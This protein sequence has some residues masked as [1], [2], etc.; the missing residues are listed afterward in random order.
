M[1]PQSRR[2]WMLIGA[3]V[4]GASALGVIAS[5]T[6]DD[7]LV[8]F[9]TPTEL[10]ENSNKARDVT[11]RLGGQVKADSKVWDQEAR[12]LEF[13]VT[14]GTT[15]V[16]VVFNGD[17]PDMFRE[18]IGVVVEGSLGGDGLFHSETLLVKHSNEYQAPEEGE[19]DP[20]MLKSEETLDPGT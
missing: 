12:H 16:P 5:G 15:D 7:N 2:R 20:E 19:T 13:I 8:Y 1:S 4:V 9:W 10:L 14:D 18:N 11:V 6:M 3:L 17:L